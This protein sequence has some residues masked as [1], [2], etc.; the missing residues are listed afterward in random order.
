MDERGIRVLWAIKGLARGGAEVLLERTAQHIDRSLFDI[1]CVYVDSRFNAVRP[2][3]E[4]DGVRV[5]CL[6]TGRRPLFWFV[7]LFNHV[8]LGDFDVVHAHSPLVAAVTRLAVRFS[9]SPRR[10][11]HVTTEH[12]MRD[13]YHVLTRLITRLTSRL[14]DHTLAVSC[15]VMQSIS[16]SESSQ[17]SLAYQGID[18]E[19]TRSVSGSAGTRLAPNEPIRLLCVANLRKQKDYPTLFRMCKQLSDRGVHYRLEIAGVGESDESAKIQQIPSEFGIASQ[20][21]FLGSREDIPS[22]MNRNDI[23]VATSTYEAGQ[24]IAYEAAA[25]GIPIVST[26]VGLMA[27][28]FT[29]GHDCLLA[30]V[31]DE[32]TLADHVQRLWLDP[33]IAERISSNALDLARKFDFSRTVHSLEETYRSL[34]ESRA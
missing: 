9:S 1:S 34:A 32:T 7:R 29:D 27:E 20:V 15:A 16:A 6:G 5:L 13:T 26:R 8:R 4:R 11:R 23:L 14:D 31:G 22:L 10:P 3:L 25:V 17:V 19:A 28:I 18:V 21:Q 12:C 30:D 33:D 24:I 2:V